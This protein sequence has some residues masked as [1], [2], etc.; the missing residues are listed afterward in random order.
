MDLFGILT[1]VV[2]LVS[3]ITFIV[4]LVKSGKTWGALNIVMLVFLFIETW[5]FMF[6]SAYVAKNRIS[7]VKAYD[8]MVAKVDKLTKTLD[9]EMRGDRI[10]PA[11]NLEK[12]LPLANEVNRI[13]L[14]RGR[15]W[16]GAI[17]QM[18][19]PSAATFKMPVALSNVPAAPASPDG[20]APAAPAN[21]DSALTP[22]SIVYMFGENAVPTGLAPTVYLGEYVVT[23]VKDGSITVKST[24]PLTAEQQRTLD[25]SETCAIY[26]VLPIDS[27]TAFAAEGSKADEENGYFG[28]MDR[29]KIEEIFNLVEAQLPAPAD[30]QSALKR[31]TD[32]IESYLLDGTQAPDTI[33]QPEQLAYRATFLKDH[34]VDVDMKGDGTIDKGGFFDIRGR[35]VDWRLKLDPE[36]G[37]ATFKKDDTILLESAA[38]RELEGQG[39]VSLEQRIYVR[40][41]VDYEFAYRDVR[42]R[43]NK[44]RQETLLVSRELDEINRTI[45]VATDQEIK[46]TDEGKRR[47]LD[48]AQFQK[49]LDVITSVANELTTRLE[50]TKAELSQLYSTMHA[51]H[52]QIINRN[53]EL[54]AIIGSGTQAP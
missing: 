11:L 4:L 31:K 48:K 27:H 53:K 50:N 22:R 14:E 52:G 21:T 45:K 26:E 43:T 34:T 40:P 12:F 24:T 2:V 32:M 54:A 6:L 39:V 47:A 35:A 5:T 42:Q 18:T 41:L 1:W 44:A 15:V 9:I 37:T 17:K 38:A 7:Y 13:A 51:L 19:G 16:R 33:Q 8:A 36:S 23:D 25:G 28:R 49:E 10:E 30:P 3:L 20:A 29:E 46:E